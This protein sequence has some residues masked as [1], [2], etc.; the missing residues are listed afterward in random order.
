MEGAPPGEAQSV[1]PDRYPFTF[2][3]V[4]LIDARYGS[5]ALN[6]HGHASRV[7]GWFTQNVDAVDLHAHLGPGASLE[8][9]R[10]FALEAL[11]AAVGRDELAADAEIIQ[12]DLSEERIA[13]FKTSVY[14][15]VFSANTIEQ[16][17]TKA[18]AALG[19]C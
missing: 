16:L 5:T 8:V 10:E 12:R 13:A 18:G 7:F 2:F 1:H 15:S 14:E 3:S 6:L 19:Q 9:Q 4:R 11:N 17:F